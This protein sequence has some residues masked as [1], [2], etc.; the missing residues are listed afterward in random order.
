MLKLAKTLL[1]VHYF[2]LIS[3]TFS[4]YYL[5]GQKAHLN[6]LQK[7]VQAPENDSTT[8]KSQ[9][10]IVVFTRVFRSMDGQHTLDNGVKM[11]RR[12]FKV[13]SC[14]ILTS[15]RRSNRTIA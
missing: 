4:I 5:I 13:I 14:K 1:G 9:A 10:N 7:L 3:F 6:D 15:I 8:T 12:Q 2:G 11:V